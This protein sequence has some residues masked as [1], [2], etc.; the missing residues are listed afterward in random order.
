MSPH[1]RN[2]SGVGEIGGEEKVKKA[3]IQ[4]T[5]N[6]DG[7]GWFISNVFYVTEKADFEEGDAD[8]ISG[9]TLGIKVGTGINLEK[10]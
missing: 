5:D 4:I 8:F 3:K 6:E 10:T 2:P 7:Q 9:D 1:G